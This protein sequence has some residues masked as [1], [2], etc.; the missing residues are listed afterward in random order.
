MPDEK[1]NVSI[2]ANSS[3]VTS[4]MEASATAVKSATTQMESALTTLKG[5]SSSA[6]A[7]VVDDLGKKIPEA[8][9]AAEN[10]LKKVGASAGAQRMGLQVLSYQINDVSTQFAMGTNPMMIFAQQGGQVVMALNMMRGS[11]GGFIGFLAGPWGAAIMGAVSILGVLISQRQRAAARAKEHAEA[12]ESL[13]DATKRLSDATDRQITSTQAS[14][15]ANIGEASALRDR[16]V[17]A[18]DAATAE[19]R[20][21]EARLKS[22]QDQMSNPIGG[23]DGQLGAAIGSLLASR[24]VDKLNERIAELNKQVQKNEETI[25]GARALQLQQEAREATDALAAASGRYQR[26]V[27]K[28]TESLA[29]GRISE[30]EYT[31]EITKAMR[32]RN[33]AEEAAREAARA[34]RSK[35]RTPGANERIR[36]WDLELQAQKNAHQL[37]NAENNTFYEFSAR[38][39]ADYWRHILSTQN[40]TNNERVQVTRKF[41][42]A[43]TTVRQ[44][45][46]D[47]SIALMRNELMQYRNN[48]EQRLAIANQIADK[49]K[50]AYGETSSQYQNALNQIAVIERQRAEQ[51][52]Q[53]NQAIVAEQQAAAVA[54]IDVESVANDQLVQLGVISQSRAIANE[55]AFEQER[56]QINLDA[57]N[58]RI[59]L[60]N[61]DPDRNPVEYQRAKDQ[62]L[63]IERDHNQRLIQLNNQRVLATNQSSLIG[64]RAVSQSWGQ[65]LSEMFV[66]MKSW[67]EGINAL[68]MGLVTSIVQALTQMVAQWIAQQL[69]AMIF[70]KASSSSTALG[71]ITANAGV[72]ASAAYAST[73][74]IPIIGPAM[75]PGAAA[76]ALAGAMAFAPMAMAGFAAEQGFDVPSGINPVTQLHQREMVLPEQYADVIRQLADNGNAKPTMPIHFY[77]PRGMTT[78]EMERHAATLVRILKNAHANREFSL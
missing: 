9:G 10:A 75:A 66:G 3:G 70:N 68:W 16:A 30:S 18:R 2:E 42:D 17:A 67:Q 50:G 36:G 59:E 73:A 22:M 34:N 20:L 28:L 33:A 52:R 7:S 31:A 71:Q 32:A 63:Q 69:A 54:R 53:I 74:A 58:Q 43:D 41:L 64:I 11:A 47:H 46:L 62:I 19:L 65:T 35:E 26:E 77:P 60:M 61:N 15:Q 6:A 38:Q 51:V 56:Y 55:M 49:I 40:L 72:A 44:E 13:E 29:K 57:L 78:S 24:N 1:I 37:Q 27:D 5:T 23:P 8:A 45:Q 48:Q 4:G 39:E 25:R 21:A 76:A 14:I 12:T